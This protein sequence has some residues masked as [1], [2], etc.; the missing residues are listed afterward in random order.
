MAGWSSLEGTGADLP[1]VY[2]MQSH[3]P[4]VLEVHGPTLLPSYIPIYGFENYLDFSLF[5]LSY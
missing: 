3:A 1:S 5:R 4:K 2:K